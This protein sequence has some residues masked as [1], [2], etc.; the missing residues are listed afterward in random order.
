MGKNRLI[1]RATILFLLIL[2]T[3]LCAEADTVSAQE[4]VHE[5]NAFQILWNAIMSTK[6][7]MWASIQVLIALTLILA[8][9]FYLAEMKN[10]EYNFRKSLVWAF[11]HYIGDPGRF[12]GKGPKTLTGRIISSI[13]GIV[14]ILIVAIPAGI[15]G[16]GFDEALQDERENKILA[17]NRTKLWRAF[18]RK[19]DRPSEFRSVLPYKSIEDIQVITGMSHDDI[20]NT[21]NATKGFRTINL[22]KT[23]P[24][25][26]N[27]DDRLVVEIFPYNRP[28]GVFID[29]GSP[30]TIVSSS[31]NIDPTIGYF[32]FYLAA[33]G[34]FNF[35]SREFG[36]LTPYESYNF[37]K[38]IDY[39]YKKEYW[40]D[41]E[42][43]LDR[44]SVW[45][46]TMVTASGSIEPKY[47]TEIHFGLGNP[48]GVTDMTDKNLMVKDLDTFQKLYD[49]FTTVAYNDWG[50]KSDLSPQWDVSNPKWWTRNLKQRPDANHIIFRM[51]WSA[52]LWND[53]RLLIA[54]TL[55]DTI[56]KE[57]LGIENPDYYPYLKEVGIAF[58][59]YAIPGFQPLESN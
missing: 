36:E 40:A 56:N 26:E 10:K 2:T 58:E 22:A 3:L 48:K 31:S 52:L 32:S 8:G 49:S 38:N 39:E 4:A 20:L 17:E 46:F 27:P 24:L 18:E 35:I 11:T 15:L 16:S 25:E 29:R 47:D 51:A 43:L 5:S 33:I 21:V 34:K 54:K 45:T 41:L 19:L 37:I 30:V 53:N 14:G 13:L 42:K 9:I 55:A 1:N 6:D 28:Y 59:G 23:V 7:S 44:D 50:I 12:S 57:I